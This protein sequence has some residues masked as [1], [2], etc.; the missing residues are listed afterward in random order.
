MCV[1]Q[2]DALYYVSYV[3]GSITFHYLEKQGP[4]GYLMTAYDILTMDSCVQSGLDMKM[5]KNIVSSV[6]DEMAEM[7]GLNLAAGQHPRNNRQTNHL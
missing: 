6:D 3:E 7:I 2:W 4:E 5:Q 1:V